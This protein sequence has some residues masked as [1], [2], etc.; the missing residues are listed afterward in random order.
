MGLAENRTNTLAYLG[1]TNKGK[2]KSFE[3]LIVGGQPSHR[4]KPSG[5]RTNAIKYFFNLSQ[6]RRKI[7]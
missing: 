4:A 1:Q 5:P 7:S 6:A 3:T 2:E